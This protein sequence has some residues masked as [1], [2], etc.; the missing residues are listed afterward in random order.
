MVSTGLL[1]QYGILAYNRAFKLRQ[2]NA[3]EAIQAFLGRL[4]EQFRTVSDSN[5]SQACAWIV[6]LACEM[7]SSRRTLLSGYEEVRDE[8]QKLIEL[9]YRWIC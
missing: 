3:K 9:V 7:S 4:R 2:C 8:L 6:Q 1:V 5:I